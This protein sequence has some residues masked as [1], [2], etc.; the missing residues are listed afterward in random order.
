MLPGKPLKTL[1]GWIQIE[2][3]K[4]NMKIRSVSDKWDIKLDI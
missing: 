4:L 1:Q 2:M 3:W